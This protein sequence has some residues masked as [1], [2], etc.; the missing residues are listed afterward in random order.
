LAGAGLAAGWQRVT[1]QGVPSSSCTSDALT[2]RVAGGFARRADVRRRL[3]GDEERHPFRYHD[4]G[5]MATIAGFPVG[6]YVGPIRVTGLAGWLAWPVVHLTFLTGFRN[7]FA[8]LA[9]WAIVFAGRARLQRTVT[10][11]EALARVQALERPRAA[12]QRASDGSNTDV[13]AA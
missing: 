9:S 10:K 1:L 11:R 8:T 5:A 4:L 3:S 13:R 7:R 12:G 2:M 6:A